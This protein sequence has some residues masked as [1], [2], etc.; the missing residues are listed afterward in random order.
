MRVYHSLF[1]HLPWEV[2]NKVI[3]ERHRE[4]FLAPRRHAARTPHCPSRHLISTPKVKP[5]PRQGQ[6]FSKSRTPVKVGPQR[7]RGSPGFLWS[8]RPHSAATRARLEPCPERSAEGCEATGLTG[9]LTLV[10]RE[11]KGWCGLGRRPHFLHTTHF[12]N[13]KAF[14]TSPVL[15]SQEPLVPI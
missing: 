15:T 9:S 12:T 6:P 7:K 5:A 1:T 8:Q 11:R 13:E 2:F 14:A 3:Q 4:L 10:H